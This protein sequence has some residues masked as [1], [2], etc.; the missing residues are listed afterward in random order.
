MNG[1]FMLWMN[2][3]I[4]YDTWQ[5]EYKITLSLSSL[6][7]NEKTLFFGYKYRSFQQK[8]KTQ[9]EG[10]MNMKDKFS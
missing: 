10:K 7:Y 2:I 9:R 3:Y 1:Y 5:V 6:T 8:F 4:S